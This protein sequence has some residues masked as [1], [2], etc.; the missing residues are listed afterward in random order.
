MKTSEVITQPKN[1]NIN[2]FVFLTL[3][4]HF[5]DFLTN[6]FC[7]KARFGHYVKLWGKKKICW[8]FLTICNVKVLHVCAAAE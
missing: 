2:N 5:V 3:F 1:E 6:F 7:R 4:Y 8:C